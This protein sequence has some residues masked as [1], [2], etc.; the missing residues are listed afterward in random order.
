M[1]AIIVFFCLLCINLMSC[2]VMKNRDFYALSEE[3]YQMS[4]VRS[5]GK[6][7]DLNDTELVFIPS[8]T[9]LVRAL[10]TNYVLWA[11][12]WNVSLLGLICHF[13]RRRPNRTSVK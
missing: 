2:S 3:E 4:D 10:K 11:I 6:E 1:R 9:C 12:T 7:Q 5:Q 8:R 13:F